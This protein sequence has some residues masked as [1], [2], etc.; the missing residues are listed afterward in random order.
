MEKTEQHLNRENLKNLISEFD[1][2]MTEKSNV[3][4][5]DQPTKKE[6][7]ELCLPPLLVEAFQNGLEEGLDECNCGRNEG[8]DCTQAASS[9]GHHGCG[10]IIPSTDKDCRESTGFDASGRL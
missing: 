4:V 1:L 8:H 9:S 10:K 6:S 3:A 7:V 5:Q 2:G